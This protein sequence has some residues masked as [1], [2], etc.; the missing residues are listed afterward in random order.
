MTRREDDQSPEPEGGRAAERLRQFLDAR[1]P[2]T[3]PAPAPNETQDEETGKASQETGDEV[4]GSAEI[5]AEEEPA[6][7]EDSEEGSSG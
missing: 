5:D 4:T 2:I 7:D 1:Q 6:S 3:E